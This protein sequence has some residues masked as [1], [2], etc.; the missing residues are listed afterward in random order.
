MVVSP[1][2]KQKLKDFGLFL[3]YPVPLWL[4]F[5]KIAREHIAEAKSDIDKTNAYTG[6]LACI[7]LIWVPMTWLWFVLAQEFISSVVGLFRN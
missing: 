7:V 5:P 6:V 3:I 2:I 4:E 1:K